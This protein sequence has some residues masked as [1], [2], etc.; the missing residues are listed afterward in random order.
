MRLPRPIHLVFLLPLLLL[1]A[2]CERQP[3]T[4]VA[5]GV[6]RAEETDGTGGEETYDLPE[7]Q[8]TGELIVLTLYGPITYFEFRG[9]RFGSQYLLADRYAR[10]IGATTRVEVCRSADEMLQKLES[11]EGDVIAANLRLPDSA[12]RGVRSCGTRELTA[13]VDTLATL[14]GD[15]SI[16]VSDSSC[17]LVRETSP[18]LRAS[19]ADWLRKQRPNLLALASPKIED[20]EGRTYMPRRHA[21]SPMRNPARGEISA[22]DHLFKSYAS[23]CGWDWRLLAAQAYQESAFDAQAVS[24]MGACGLLQLMPSTAKMVGVA[25]GEL[26]DA[27]RNVAGA[28]RYLGQLADHYSDIRN[29]DDRI[30][31]M[32]AAYNAGP[33]HVDDVRALARKYGHDADKWADVER[34]VP[35]MTE[36][37]FYNDPVVRHGYFRGSETYNYVRDIRA[38]W[39]EYRRNI[40]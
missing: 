14:E 8:E 35:R 17:W 18:Q 11:G 37:K 1:P 12:P 13:L 34:Y 7:I 30:N 40:R 21:A 5:D 6:F 24:W 26:F 27:E 20:D 32:L 23:R 36:R 10:S 33:G 38:R 3:A 19:L 16:V 31:F 2:A 15:S 4:H 39:E 22:Y 9:E 28:V 25:R 29:R